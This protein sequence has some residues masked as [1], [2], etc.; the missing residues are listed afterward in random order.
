MTK[1]LAILIALMAAPAAAAAIADQPVRLKRSPPVA[2]GIASMPR[3]M[4]NNGDHVATRINRALAI[5]SQIS[6]CDCRKGYWHR[7]VA[8]TMRG[9]RY[10]SLLAYDD[11]YCGGAYPDTDQVAL[12]FNLAIGAP[13][14]WQALFPA[15]FVE[16]SGA[17]PGGNESTPVS[18]GSSAL[19]KLYNE[20]AA[21]LPNDKECSDVLKDP[22]DANL[23]LWPDAEGDGLAM[24]PSSFPHVVKACGAPITI[25]TSEL[26]QLGVDGEFLAALHEAH[27]R[28]WYDKTQR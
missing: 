6:G 27:Q 3:I 7:T 20:R 23:M 11:W 24:Q 8:V 21:A 12:V 25:P 22:P 5:A 15:G 28:G 9:P 14:D 10:L 18:V 16:A 13:P 1:T 19:W 2:K 17:G 4:A 26:R